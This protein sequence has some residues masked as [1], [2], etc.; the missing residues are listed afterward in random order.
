[1]YAIANP[2]CCKALMACFAFAFLFMTLKLAL[3]S[4]INPTYV[5]NILIVLASIV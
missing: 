5:P 4:L 3:N 1:M 2:F